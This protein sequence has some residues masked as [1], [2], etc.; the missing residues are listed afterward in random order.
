MP[1]AG[2]DQLARFGGSYDGNNKFGLEVVMEN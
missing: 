1:S 2:P